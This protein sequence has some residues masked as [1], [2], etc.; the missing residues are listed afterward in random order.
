MKNYPTEHADLNERTVTETTTNEPENKKNNAVLWGSLAAATLIGGGILGFNLLD[1]GNSTVP[2]ANTVLA[3]STQETCKEFVESKLGCEIVF[4]THETI[5]RDSLIRQSLAPGDS[6]S[7]GSDV[8]LVYSKGP[9]SSAFPDL[10]GMSVEEAQKALYNI[11]VDVEKINRVH[12][13]EIDRDKVVSASVEPGST[14]NN[15]DTVTLDVADGY[16]DLPD[17]TG[18]TSEYVNKESRKLGIEVAFVEEESTQAEGTVLSQNPGSGQVDSATV[19]EVTVAKPAEVSTA[20]IPNVI[21]MTPDAAKTALA[22]AGFTKINEIQQESDKVTEIK[23]TQMIPGANDSV[24]TDTDIVIIVSYPA[25]D[26]PSGAAKETEASPSASPS[27]SASEAPAE[28]TTSPSA[29]PSSN[30]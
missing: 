1:G 25:K 5:Q 18:Q 6:V 22:S 15:G 29:S 30:G 16:V 23:V 12:D 27:A 26:A 11:G 8:T 7:K 14:V 9:A 17:W 28:S 19:V 20:S 3:S 4:E 13:P 2:R 24:R 21:N 10:A